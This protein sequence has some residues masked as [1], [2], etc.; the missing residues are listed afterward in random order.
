METSKGKGR[1]AQQESRSSQVDQYHIRDGQNMQHW[2]RSLQFVLIV[3]PIR[4][5]MDAGN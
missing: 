5:W 1:R 4:F 2:V 3:G